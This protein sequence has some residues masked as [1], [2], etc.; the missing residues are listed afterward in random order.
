MNSLCANIDCDVD[1]NSP[2]GEDMINAAYFSDASTSAGY[3]TS[4]DASTSTSVDASTSTSVDSSTSP[5]Y[6]ASTS[7]SVD[8]S[9]SSGY[10]SSSVDA[11]TSAPASTDVI[12]EESPEYLRKIDYCRRVFQS[13][14]ES[15]TAPG[16]AEDWIKSKIK[17]GTSAPI[18]Q[19]SFMKGVDNFLDS[20]TRLIGVTQSGKQSGTLTHASRNQALNLAPTVFFTQNIIKELDR[21]KSDVSEL[22]K[23][24]QEHGKHIASF[25][26]FKGMIFPE[27]V[28][29]L[30]NDEWEESLQSFQEVKKDGLKNIPIIVCLGN[31]TLGGRITKIGNKLWEKGYIMEEEYETRYENG[32]PVRKLVLPRRLRAHLV[33]DEADKHVNASCN[34]LLYKEKTIRKNRRRDSAPAESKGGGSAP[35]ESKGGGSA[36][37]Y[38]GNTGNRFTNALYNEVITI[39]HGENTITG[40]I[41][42]IFACVTEATA[43]PAS[44]FY[45]AIPMKGKKH[46]VM[47]EVIPGKYYYGYDL[48]DLSRSIVR[49]ETLSW[50]D[51]GEHMEKDDTRHR[52]A[53]VIDKTC[54]V[55]KIDQE[56]ESYRCAIKFPNILSQTWSADG[57]T[58]CVVHEL[59]VKDNDFV[60]PNDLGDLKPLHRLVEDAFNGR[61]IRD[62]DREKGVSHKSQKNVKLYYNRGNWHTEGSLEKAVARWVKIE[63]QKE[64]R[65]KKQADKAKK[66]DPSKKTYVC[67]EFFA[68]KEFETAIKGAKDK[69]EVRNVAV[70]SDTKATYRNLLS[71]LALSLRTRNFHHDLGFLKTMLFGRDVLDRGVNLKGDNHEFPLT[72][73]FINLDLHYTGLI[74]ACGRL[75]GNHYHDCDA[76]CV[77]VCKEKM[78]GTDSHHRCTDRCE[79]VCT[80][81]IK[82]LWGKKEVLDLHENGLK[83]NNLLVSAY[84]ENGLKKFFT[85]VEDMR[86]IIEIMEAE[87]IT[88]EQLV[89]NSAKLDEFRKKKGWEQN[90]AWELYTKASL[91]FKK[92]APGTFKTQDDG[93]ETG[94]ACIK[95]GLKIHNGSDSSKRV[96]Y[97][98]KSE[99]SESVPEFSFMEQIKKLLANTKYNRSWGVSNCDESFKNHLIELERTPNCDIVR[100][101]GEGVVKTSGIF[102]KFDPQDKLVSV[103]SKGGKDGLLRAYTK[104]IVQKDKD[105]FEERPTYQEGTDVDMTTVSSGSGSFEGAGSGNFEGA[106]IEGAGSGSCEGAGSGN[107]E[108]AEIEGAGSGNFEGAEIEG[109][110]SGSFGPE[111]IIPY[112]ISFLEDHDGTAL[113]KDIVRFLF[114]SGDICRGLW[115]NWDSRESSSRKSLLWTC[116]ANFERSGKLEKHGIHH[117]MNQPSGLLL[118]SLV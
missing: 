51:M 82:V 69:G 12:S 10:P 14:V 22:N 58:A 1:V 21:L 117:V 27:I 38:K 72:D 26:E 30:E 40:I 89:G 110:E 115:K 62:T 95:R 111:G 28:F 46:V 94:K 99:T 52:Q 45:A 75:C 107:F 116:L 57:I 44:L 114:S 108:G 92:A 76:G 85:C 106:E 90:A 103:T 34:N 102:I 70:Y 16:K 6:P 118:Y 13:I 2:T 39:G 100:K 93:V 49:K 11:S 23:V 17:Y 20:Y 50:M 60:V 15:E 48:D 3:P 81:T 37:V 35:A 19:E 80:Q 66:K 71:M 24:F 41:I 63:T 112:V 54:T 97:C 68:D 31:E 78:V 18:V 91:F 25:D 32:E 77:M 64:E 73:E 5:G 8:A 86:E 36:P 53:V 98:P 87:F 29:H 105:D 104:A 109:A 84:K 79:M 9:T 55:V 33:R 88:R 7:S 47:L 43:S 56:L 59:E 61:P 83:F 96:K 67:K 101:D 4:V 113:R 65:K 42:E 74:H